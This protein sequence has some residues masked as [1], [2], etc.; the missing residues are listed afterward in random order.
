MH[1]AEIVDDS[2]KGIEVQPEILQSGLSASSIQGSAITVSDHGPFVPQQNVSDT[3]ATNK[4]NRASL[5]SPVGGYLQVELA[6]SSNSNNMT[7]TQ[8]E[9][10]YTT[11]STSGQ[12]VFESV[13]TNRQGPSVFTGEYT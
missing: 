13:L 5:C 2:G 6:Q 11:P 3:R 8:Q 12:S 7:F 10:H 1:T 9:V 4:N